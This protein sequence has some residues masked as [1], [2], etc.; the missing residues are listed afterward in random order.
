MLFLNQIVVCFA[1]PED[2][3]PSSWSIF[4]QA[5]R[6]GDSGGFPSS[7]VHDR[8]GLKVVCYWRYFSIGIF[9]NGDLFCWDHFLRLFFLGLFYWDFGGFPSCAVHDRAGLKVV[10]R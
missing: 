2:K 5:A 8:A 6:L 4:D 3:G 9:F 7:A 10:C 1:L